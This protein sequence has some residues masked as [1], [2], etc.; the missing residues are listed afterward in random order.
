MLEH[1]VVHK[2]EIKMKK[3]ITILALLMLM[4]IPL[5][6]AKL[7]IEEPTEIFDDYCDFTSSDDCLLNVQFFQ[8]QKHIYTETGEHWLL[9]YFGLVPWGNPNGVIQEYGGSVIFQGEFEVGDLILI[10]NIDSGLDITRVD[11]TQDNLIIKLE[12]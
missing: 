6:F 2:E 3:Q 5:T 1:L 9:T 12:N 10:G 8:P 7:Q 4:V 11:A